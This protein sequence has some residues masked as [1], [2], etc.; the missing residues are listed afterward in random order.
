VANGQ[1]LRLHSGTSVSAFTDLT[2][3]YTAAPGYLAYLGA[4]LAVR[5]APNIIGKLPPELVRAETAC[6]MG[7]V[8]ITPP[9][10]DVDGYG[11]NNRSSGNI[12]N[13]WR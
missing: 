4:A 2:T 1:T 10:V 9:I 3:N 7:L 5:I 11:G 13:G 8:N 12:L 6:E